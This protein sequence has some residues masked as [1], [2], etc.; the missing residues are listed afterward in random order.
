MSNC[1]YKLAGVPT[2]ID[3]SHLMHNTVFTHATTAC[4]RYS[5]ELVNTVDSNQILLEQG[6]LLIHTPVILNTGNRY[7][8]LEFPD[9]SGL[10]VRG[11]TYRATD[12][13][14]G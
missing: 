11:Y 6:L 3:I 10:E 2:H 1:V 9:H 12:K 5:A 4:K 13:D 8:T 7:S 14:I